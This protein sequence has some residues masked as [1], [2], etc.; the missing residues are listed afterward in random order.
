MSEQA[1]TQAREQHVQFSTTVK[2]FDKYIEALESFREEGIVEFRDDQV[3]SKVV[4][5]SNVG[6]A[7]SRIKGQALNSLDLNSDSSM[8]AGLRFER[9]RDCLKGTPNTSELEV[10]WPVVSQSTE[11]I[12]LRIVD[13]ELEFELNTLDVDS[14]PDI[15][16]KEPLSHSTR[17]VVDGGELKKAISHAD[18]IVDSD[19]GSIIFE[20]FED[21][22]QL[23]AEDKV[24]GRFNKKFRQSGPSEEAQLEEHQTEVAVNM[25]KDISGLVGSGDEVVAHVKDSHPLRLDVQLDDVG[26]AEV[27]FLVAPRLAKD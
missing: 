25:L 7:V 3:F 16:Q 23:R 2:Y 20:T 21:V 18:K 14:V 13:Q 15:P 1:Q 8:K 24:E 12:R 4:T 5:P 26:D 9:I 17:I 19:S 22:F 10:T 6:M 11:K 27:V